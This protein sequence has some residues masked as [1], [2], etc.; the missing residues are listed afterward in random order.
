VNAWTWLPPEPL[1]PLPLADTRAPLSS[2]LVRFGEERLLDA[3]LAA[4]FGLLRYETGPVRIQ[5]G[6]VAAAFMGFQAAGELTFELET[7]DGTFAFPVDLAWRRLGLR[8][9]WAHTSAHFAD[10]V[11]NDDDRPT[12]F[13]SWSREAVQVQAGW[14]FELARPYLGASAVTH[15]TTKGAPW[16]LQAGGELWGPWGVAPYLAGDVRL[17]AENGWAPAWGGQVGAHAWVG[18]Q[19]L[20]LALAARSGPEDTGKLSGRDERWLGLLFAFD[21]G[22]GERK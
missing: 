10:G 3:T 6:L 22:V 9:Q 2:V 16:A 12:D 1:F 21:A 8:A 14:R 11:R 15:A 4:D 20:R 18:R 7:F 17:A 13:E 19:R 5:G